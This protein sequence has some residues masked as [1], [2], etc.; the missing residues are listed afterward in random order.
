[1]GHFAYWFSFTY[2]G[3][4][5]MTKGVSCLICFITADSEVFFVFISFCVFSGT[6]L[7]KSKPN[8]FTLSITAV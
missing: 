4:S 5:S 8:R 1:M 7:R 3:F 2:P 6:R